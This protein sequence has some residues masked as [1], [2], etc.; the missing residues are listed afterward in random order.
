MLTFTCPHLD[1]WGIGG[2]KEPM[3]S[4]A[5]QN[6]SFENQVRNLLLQDDLSFQQ[7]PNF[8]YVC[9]NIM[10]KK[11][12][13]K[14]SIV[15]SRSSVIGPLALVH[16]T[17]FRTPEAARSGIFGGKAMHF[18]VGLWCVSDLAASIWRLRGC[19]MNI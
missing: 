2:L 14:A 15:P 6:L 19:G 12:G 16:R 8:A 7:D 1:P 4:A 5:Q 11:R 9:W 17:R 13:S 10:Q 3:R 18:G